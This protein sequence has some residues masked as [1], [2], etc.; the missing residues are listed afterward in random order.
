MKLRLGVAIVAMMM[1]TSSFSQI[2]KGS[3]LLGG[4][5]GFTDSKIENP[6]SFSLSSYQSQKEV[7]VTVSPNVSYFVINKLSVGLMPSYTFSSTSVSYSSD[8]K[9]NTFSI[10]PVVRYYFPYK[11]W[12]LFPEVSFS[13]GVSNISDGY[14]NSPSS[15]IIVK[16]SAKINSIKAGVGMTYF[17]TRNIGLEGKLF[18]QK[19]E[20]TYDNLYLVRGVQTVYFADNT[21]SSIAFNLGVQVY[22]S[23][24]AA[25]VK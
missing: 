1:A 17:L 14:Y 22:F 2:E 13:L 18:Y 11:S 9:T 7:S 19:T 15:E 21:T 10:G 3:F 6:N 24:K 25:E 23:R 12:A 16:N 8:L 20:T 5:L 4:S